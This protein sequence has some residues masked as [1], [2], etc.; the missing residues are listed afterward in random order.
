VITEKD[1]QE[2][3]AECKGQR[4]PT[5]QTCIKLA[6]FLTI[7]RELFGEPDTGYSYAPPPE[8]IENTIEYQ[9]DTEFGKMIS[10]KDPAKVWPVMD[11]LMTA[12]YVYNKPLYDATMR[13][14]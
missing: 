1:L 7:Q 9:S 3:I 2:A 14:L 11:E 5:S 10:G 8:P 12:T 4:N 13:R 6:A